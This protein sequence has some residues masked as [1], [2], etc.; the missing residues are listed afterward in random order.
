[1]ST[2]LPQAHIPLIDPRNP[3]RI[4]KPWHDYFRSVGGIFGGVAGVVGVLFGGT[5]LSTYARGDT[6][7]ASAVDTLAK[8]AIGTSGKV[9]QS[10]GV[11]PGWGVTLPAT[12]G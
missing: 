7:Y 4:N 10:N 3:G 8:L 1:M 6:L 2:A 5:G 9:L 11:I 12:V